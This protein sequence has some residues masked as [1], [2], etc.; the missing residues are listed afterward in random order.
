MHVTVVGS[1]R[2]LCVRYRLTWPSLLASGRLQCLSGATINGRRIFQQQARNATQ[3]LTIKYFGLSAQHSQDNHF[4]QI[5]VYYC[6][7][8]RC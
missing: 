2:I 7:S 6:Y 8:N 5:A 1:V 4:A 3:P